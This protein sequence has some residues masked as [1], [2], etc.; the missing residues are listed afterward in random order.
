MAGGPGAIE[1]TKGWGRAGM[2]R[3]GGEQWSGT[4]I[5]MYVCPGGY[6]KRR[7][8]LQKESGLIGLAIDL[9]LSL[10]PSP[11]SFC[12]F[13]SLPFCLYL[14]PLPFGLFLSFPFCLYHSL[15]VFLSPFL[16]RLPSRPFPINLWKMYNARRPQTAIELSP[17]PS[18]TLVRTVVVFRAEI[19]GWPHP[20]RIC[21]HRAAV[22]C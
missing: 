17:L 19:T 1:K 5:C 12:L 16:S 7:A 18:H 13:L 6:R 3:T 11:L 8:G 4:C 10:S 21:V 20:S 9:S 2:D 22:K 15:S 14:S